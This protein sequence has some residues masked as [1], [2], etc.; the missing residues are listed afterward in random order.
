M[1][2]RNINLIFVSKTC[3]HCLPKF[4]DIYGAKILESNVRSYLQNKT[5]VNKKI[6]ETI[7]DQGGYVFCIQQWAYSYCIRN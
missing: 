5:K 3:E 6:R 4:M 7:E 1:V 2:H